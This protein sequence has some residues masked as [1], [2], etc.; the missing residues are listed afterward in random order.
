MRL[1]CQSGLLGCWL[2]PLD[3]VSDSGV[4]GLRNCVWW[5][6]IGCKVCRY[7][8]GLIKK[9]NWSRF[10]TNG[11]HGLTMAGSGLVAYLR[12]SG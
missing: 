12:L 2:H 4:G 11:G 6:D 9:F 10:E 8:L 3:G 1:R 5:Q 7:V